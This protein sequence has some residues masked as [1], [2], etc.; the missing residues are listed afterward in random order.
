MTDEPYV[1]SEDA[2]KTVAE[3]KADTLNEFAEELEEELESFVPFDALSAG[4]DVEKSAVIRKL[5]ERAEK[6]MEEA[7]G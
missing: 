5:R 1:P 2:V 7:N 4:I 3:I 6:I